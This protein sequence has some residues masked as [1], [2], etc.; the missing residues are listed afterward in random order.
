VIKESQRLFPAVY[1][2]SR[3]A[4]EPVDVGGFLLPKGAQVHLVPYICH[5]DDR[6]WHEP[7]RFDPERFL[8]ERESAIRTGAYF[9]FGAGPRACIGKSFALMEAQIILAAL[10]SRYRLALDQ[11]DPVPETQVSLHPKGGLKIIGTRR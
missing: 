11:E 8:P 5:H 2:M 3:E 7:E 4:H 10:L 1:F 9:P 6:W